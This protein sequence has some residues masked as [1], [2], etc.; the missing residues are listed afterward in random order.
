M[1]PVSIANIA[2]NIVVVHPPEDKA[3]LEAFVTDVKSVLWNL[4]LC[5]AHQRGWGL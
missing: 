5:G 3:A 2:V 4:L 1:F